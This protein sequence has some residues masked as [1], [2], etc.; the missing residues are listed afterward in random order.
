M[1][2]A[3]VSSYVNYDA[4]LYNELTA[5]YVVIMR[6]FESYRASGQAYTDLEFIFSILIYRKD[7]QLSP[8]NQRHKSEYLEYPGASARDTGHCP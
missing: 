2:V 7:I 6:S 4:T 5:E 1:P 3:A 8:A